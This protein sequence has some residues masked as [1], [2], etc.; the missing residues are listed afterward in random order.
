MPRASKRKLRPLSDDDSD[1]PE[2][3]RQG[4][5]QRLS[6]SRSDTTSPSKAGDA[7]ESCASEVADVQTPKLKMGHGEADLQPAMEARSGVRHD[8]SSLQSEAN[9]LEAEMTMM[10]FAYPKPKSK[11][12]GLLWEF[13]P[14]PGPM[15]SVDV[16]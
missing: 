4:G 15:L 9:D 16:D 5:K 10:T 1:G 13:G 6:G 11:F 3:P 14:P 12:V 7:C 8:K 2:A